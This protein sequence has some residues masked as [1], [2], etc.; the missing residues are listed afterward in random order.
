MPAGSG[1]ELV[2]AP[3]V[4][5]TR[6]VTR[7]GQ[8]CPIARA[9]EVLGDRWT[10]LILREL[11]CGSRGFNEIARGLPR[12]SRSVLSTRM[13]SLESEGLVT[14]G[15]GGYELTAA[16]TELKPVLFGLGEWGARWGFQ[17]PREDELDPVV[18]M[19]WIHRGIDTQLLPDRRVVVEFRFRRQRGRFWLLITRGDVGVCESD[20]GFDSDIVVDADLSTMFGVWLGR[21]RL[22]D[23]QRDDLVC[24]AGPPGLVR[25]F[26]RSLEFSPISY[27]VRDAG[28][29]A[30]RHRP[31]NQPV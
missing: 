4:R 19:W 30:A 22:V 2:R 3:A 31:A 1:I 8:Y 9:A 24:F 16:G 12:M 7:Y 29:A 18:L 14:R 5:D 17:D 11:I 23:A 25:T 27:A 26:V 21:E 6:A 20:P 15:D 13:R 10:L 28:R